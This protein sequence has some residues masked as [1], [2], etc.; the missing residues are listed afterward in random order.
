MLGR[1]EAACR[2]LDSP[3]KARILISAEHSG[4]EV[5]A[6]LGDL[7]IGQSELRRHIGYDIGIEGVVHRLHRLTGHPAILGRFSRLVADVNRPESSPECVIEVSDGTRIPGNAGLNGQER[8]ERIRRFHR[9]FHKAFTELVRR[10][11]PDCIVSVHSFTPMLRTE[12]FSRPWHCGI[13]YGPPKEQA[14]CCIRYLRGLQGMIVGD[15]QPYR[16]DSHRLMGPKQ[17][18]GRS[19]PTIVVEIRQDLIGDCVG[20]ERWAA[21]LNGLLTE[22]LTDRKVTGTGQGLRGGPRAIAQ[23][24]GI[25]AR[26]PASGDRHQDSTRLDH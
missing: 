7:G 1:T 16:F 10:A 23:N 15:N 9:P 6:E 20:Q 4:V 21:I 25:A 5:P 18:D 13:L 8:K 2:I 26:G 19:I 24:T 3:G 11:R 17:I 14:Q 22:C 12:G